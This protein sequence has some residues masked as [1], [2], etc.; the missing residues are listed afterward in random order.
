[1][2]NY[3]PLRRSITFL[4]LICSIFFLHL[5][6]FAQK[7]K[8]PAV[9]E[10]LPFLINEYNRDLSDLQRVYIFPVS[11]EYFTRITQ[12]RN[13]WIKKLNQI[14][15]DKLSISDQVDYTLLKRNIL[16]DQHE[17][18]IEKKNYA[19]ISY[20]LPFD[21]AII[22]L[23]QKRRRGNTLD[24]KEVAESLNKVI[25]SISEART[26]VKKKP[27]SRKELQQMVIRSVQDLKKGLKNVY[28]FY[29]GYD[30]DFTWWMKYTYPQADSALENYSKWIA[31]QPV[32]HPE[33][34]VDKSGIAGNPIG[35]EEIIRQLQ[36]QMIPYTPEE[37]IEIS[38]QQYEWCEK[39]MIKVSQQL[40]FGNDWKKALEKIK[41]NHLEPGK[42]PA[43]INRLQEEAIAFI[44]KN[45][46]ITIPQLAREV[47]RM[48]MLSVQQMRFASYFLGGPQILIAFPHEDQ[49]YETK[50]MIMRSGNYG[51]AHAEVFHELIPG[52]NLQSFMFG[53]YKPY[54][55]NF[56]SP[57]SMEGWPFYW[58]MILWDKG[59]DKTPDEKIGA[60]FWRMT[61][62]VRIVFS[63][64]YHLGNWTPQQCIDYMVEKAGLERFSAESEVRRSFTGGYGPLYQLAYMIGALQLYGLHHELVDS[65]RISEK[66]FNNAYLQEGP[67]PIEM[68]RSIILNEKT[69]KDFTTKWK[70]MD[71]VRMK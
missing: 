61:R 63:L 7:I 31:A 26:E 19:G 64:N 45:D 43:L 44:D 18:E 33:E 58:E 39:E 40:G 37:L 53:R 38:K 12:F 70:F 20:A 11:N 27:I 51:F 62:C 41:Q 46:L 49:D 14:N 10:S 56:N 47:W 66:D 65:G 36:Y 13:D 1:M 48:D 60:L 4:Y 23:Q 17:L 55:N 35:R 34:P 59:F 50:E 8:A 57:F 30:P 21:N 71:H 68:F 28:S 25:R 52:H 6:L 16:D 24:S 69:G 42:Q 3:F 9:E 22:S 5:Q 67:I 54:R 15:T 2:K 29:N 32:A